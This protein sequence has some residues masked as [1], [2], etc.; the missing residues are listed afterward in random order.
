M[1]ERRTD[2]D[3]GFLTAV[4]RRTLL[5]TAASG[6]VLLGAPAL[7]GRQ[8]AGAQSMDM[9]SF[10]NARIDWKQAS[11]ANITI[12][13]TPAGYFNNL[14]AVLPAFNEMTGINAR[15]EMT[16]PG[17]IR[18]KAVLDLSS[19]TGTWASHAADPMYYDLYVANNWIDPLDGYLGDAKLTD[20]DWFDYE[21]ILEGWR[22]STSIDGKPYGMPFDGEATVQVYRKDVYSERGLKAAETLEEYVANAKAVHDPENR[23]WGAALRGFKGAGQ[24]MYIYPSIF[25]EFGGE[26]F[27][28]ERLVVDSEQAIAALDWYVQL[29]NTYSPSGVENWNWPDIADAFGQGTLGSYIDAHSSAAVI[30]DPTKSKVVGKIAFARWPKGPSGKRCTSIWNWSFPINAALPEKEKAAT[31]LFLQWAASKE[32][33][34]ATSYAFPGAYKRSGVNRTSLWNDEA[35]TAEIAKLGDN[36]I[37]A[38]TQSFE[39]DTDV[40]WRPRLPQWPAVGETMATAIQAALVGQASVKDALTEAQSRIDGILKG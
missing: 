18:Q 11:G 15:L 7:I 4:S 37:E 33:Q 31:W 9:A 12:G 3:K 16:P 27:D 22:G 38:T 13:V 24:N 28:G 29:L 34:A 5:K 10:E 32:T 21:D 39:Q 30:A 19:G 40:E 6:A 35:Y 20:N 14:E 17:Q 8:R 26:W 36:L 25:R 2:R 1:T 23:L